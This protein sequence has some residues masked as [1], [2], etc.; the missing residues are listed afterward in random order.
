MWNKWIRNKVFN[1]IPILKKKYAGFFAQ[2][3]F[4]IIKK[5]HIV[6]LLHKV[7]S[8][9]KRCNKAPIKTTVKTFKQLRQL[10]K[11]NIFII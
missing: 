5:Y 6:L 3:V 1:S 11:V 8:L 9:C 2:R 10:I 7:Y 4:K